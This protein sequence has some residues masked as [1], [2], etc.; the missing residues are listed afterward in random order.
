MQIG[1]PKRVIEVEPEHIPDTV[2][3]APVTAPA[4]P[5]KVPA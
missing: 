4:E 1:E 3:A 5:E 2:P